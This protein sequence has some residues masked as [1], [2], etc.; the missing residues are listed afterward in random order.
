MTF[1]HY[2]V[3]K[4]NM[5]L[6]KFSVIE[7]MMRPFDFEGGKSQDT[8]KYK[9]TH[10][11]KKKQFY[12]DVIMLLFQPLPYFNPT[13]TITCIN[14]SDKTEMITVEY[15]ISTILLALMFLRFILIIRS[16]I[17]YSTYTD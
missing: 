15:R 5:Q 11:Y 16:A 8:N 6:Y 7:C 3:Q 4:W 9:K 1:R 13:F 2:Y 10:F 17:N 14:Y 12:Y